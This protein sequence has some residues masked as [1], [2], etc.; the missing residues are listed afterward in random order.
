MRKLLNRTLTYYSGFALLMLLLATPFFYWISQRLH[1]EDVDEAIELRRQEFY[2]AD[3]LNHLN[4]DDLIKWNSFNRDIK[5][6]PD[7]V[8]ASKGHIIQQ[9]FYDVL[10]DEWEPYRVLY[11]NIRIEGN[12]AVLM[13]RINLIESEDLMQGALVIFVVILLILLAGFVITTKVISVRLWKPFYQTLNDIRAFDIERREVPDFVE[14]RTFEFMQLNRA[15][16]NLISQNIKAFDLEK[17]FTQNASHELQ[18]PLAIFQSKLDLLLQTRQ[19]NADQAVILQQ[20]YD[21][22]S[23]LLRIN[24]NLLLLSKIEHRQFSRKELVNV[25]EAI[26]EVLPW[27]KEQAE[28]KELLIDLV[29]HGDDVVIEANKG[30]TEILIN[31]LFM[32]AIRHNVRNGRI[33]VTLSHEQLSLANTGGDEPLN[34]ENMFLRFS[35]NRESHRG[36]GLGLAI[37]KSIA[38]LNEWDVSYHFRDNFHLFSVRFSKF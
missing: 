19:L 27:F 31:N 2:A 10:A 30:L 8:T 13:I 38:I 1:L 20:L 25:K 29:I 26:E 17:E 11:E 24:K 33:R 5:I 9:V 21:A 12:S 36:S 35:T 28:E 16:K 22:S 14:S 32:N 15:L 18:T 34:K 37:V 3:H 23:R 4:G 7:T 6:L